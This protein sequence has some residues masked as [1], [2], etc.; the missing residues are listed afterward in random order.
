MLRAVFHHWPETH[1]GEPVRQFAT[2]THMRKWLQMKAGHREISSEDDLKGK[3]KE[4]ALF[5]AEAAFRGAKT[6]AVP[7][8]HNGTLIIFNPLSI[9]FP[10]LGHKE[11]CAL[12][13]EIEQVIRDQTGLDPE[14]CLKEHKEEV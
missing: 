7:V 5:V 2:E 11:F 6:Y 3:S 12:N 14:Q 9:A 4:D 1:E 8:I 10:K 13:D